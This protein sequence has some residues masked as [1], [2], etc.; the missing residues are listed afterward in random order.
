[1]AKRAQIA[2]GPN[3]RSGRLEAKK[4]GGASPVLLI[5]LAATVLLVVGL[6][7]LQSQSLRPNV[8]VSGK[9]SEGAT[10]GPADAPVKVVE[11]SD[12]GCS[13]CR[14]FALNQGKQLRAEYEATGKVRFEYRHFII[15][16]PT[17]AGAANAAEC[18]AAQGRF[19]DYH[20]LLFAQ[21]GVGRDP[22][23]KSNLKT[24]ATQVGLD[25]ASFN[26]CVDTDQFLESVYRQ[27]N[28][29]KVAG[30]N[31]TP[32]IFVN[33]RKIEGAAPYADLKAVVEAALT[34]S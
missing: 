6:I 12:F 24:L 9:S 1:M 10:W 15:E 29:G 18:A 22:F 13:F 31:A 19:W 14:Q 32:T 23:S 3:V 34:G 17:T 28:E 5:I 26:R 30:V 11:F 25:A 2:K 27:A 33:E 8:Q 4:K 21:Q 16:G 20:D 7:I